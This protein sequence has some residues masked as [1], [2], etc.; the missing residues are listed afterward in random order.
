MASHQG[1]ADRFGT[2]NL[3]QIKQRELELQNKNTVSNEDK[4]VKCFTLY[5]KSIGLE[6]TN[7]FEF[8]EDE[9]DRHLVTW[10]FN[11]QTKN[12]EH[13]TTGSLTTLR[14]GLNRALKKAG[15][16]FDITKRECTQF[17]TSID[18]FE[19][20]KKELKQMGKGHVKNTPE[21]TQTRK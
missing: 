6:N 16:K 13:Y 19:S 10:Y 2:M 9:L 17:T 15:K 20:A 11:A 14:Y 3:D 18:A 21:I 7:F 5:L 12:K 4:A 1:D 8:S